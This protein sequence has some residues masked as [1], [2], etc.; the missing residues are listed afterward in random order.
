MSSIFAMGRASAVRCA[1]RDVC[2]P[3]LLP[4]PRL[5]ARR[6]R[7]RRHRLARAEGG[8][9][10]DRMHV[11][12][13]VQPSAVA[14][15]RTDQ[16]AAGAAQEELGL[17]APL[18]IA[19]RGALVTDAQAHPAPRVGDVRRVVLAAEVAIAGARVVAAGLAGQRERDADVAAVASAAQ[20]GHGA[21]H[22]VCAPGRAST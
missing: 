10:L 14:V 9:A 2:K 22:Y 11:D 4:A 21:E 5:L 16:Y 13:A 8:R 20:R 1:E 15:E 19:G 18:C 6:Q 7:L 17:P 3:Q 12:G